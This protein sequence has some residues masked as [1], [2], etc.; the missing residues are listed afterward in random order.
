MNH[1]NGQRFVF[2]AGSKEIC[3]A[4]AFGV[5]CG[6]GSLPPA[7]GFQVLPWIF[8]W[9]FYIPDHAFSRYSRDSQN[10]SL[11]LYTNIAVVPIKGIDAVLLQL[12]LELELSG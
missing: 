7:T 2:S 5:Q 8:F 9:K 12:E 11:K 6:I 1:F 4:L 3:C 10:A